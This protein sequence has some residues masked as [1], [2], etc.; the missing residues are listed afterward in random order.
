MWSQNIGWRDFLRTN[1]EHK[2][3]QCNQQQQVEMY[4]L[5]RRN[6][7]EWR[8]RMLWWCQIF[9]VAVLL[10]NYVCILCTVHNIEDRVINHIDGDYIIYF[11][12]AGIL[13]RMNLCFD[14][15][16]YSAKLTLLYLIFFLHTKNRKKNGYRWRNSAF[17]ITFNIPKAQKSVFFFLTIFTTTK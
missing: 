1:T 4:I 11:C 17:L 12:A 5:K 9:G 15:V 7:R 6:V 16:W 14:T 10:P 2:S 3:T 13:T 8:M